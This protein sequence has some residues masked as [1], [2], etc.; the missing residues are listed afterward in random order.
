MAAVAQAMLKP[1]QGAPIPKELFMNID[2]TGVFV[3]DSNEPVIVRQESKRKLAE[4]R[5]SVGRTNTRRIRRYADLMPLINAAGDTVCSVGIVEDRDLP[6]GKLLLVSQNIYQDSINCS[7][8]REKAAVPVGGTQHHRVQ[9]ADDASHP[10][11][12]LCPGR[13][14]R[15]RR[16]SAPIGKR[17]QCNANERAR[18]VHYGGCTGE[19]ENH[20]VFRWRSDVPQCRHGNNGGQ[21]WRP[22]R[23]TPIR[24]DEVLRGLQHVP[25]TSRRLPMLHG[26]Q[27]VRATVAGP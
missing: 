26:L 12:G 16:V 9:E 5:K 24:A 4:K 19:A 22:S 17:R 25:A 7:A 14:R 20:M 1:E 11:G 27:E 18:R 2:T 3:G 23:I 10:P 6:E 21:R 13:P 15:A 8:R